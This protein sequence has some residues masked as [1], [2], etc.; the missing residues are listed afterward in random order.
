V[1]PAYLFAHAAYLLIADIFN[2]L[3]LKHLL[4]IM[5]SVW[6]AVQ[7]SAQCELSIS[8]HILRTG[9]PE[10]IPGVT[11]FI[12]ETGQYI[13]SDSTG[14]Y[15]VDNLCAGTYTI[16]LTAAGYDPLTERIVAGK[17]LHKDLWLRA[18]VRQLQAV[19]VLG[20]KKQDIVT[21]TTA[22]ISGLQLFQAG[23]MTLGESLKSVPGLNSIQTGPSISKPVIHGLHSNRVLILN[24]G[25]RQEGQQWGTE[26]A[27]EIDPFIA[28][29]ITI[30]KGA[31]S[32]R[33]GSDALAG[34]LLVEPRALQPE[35][36][37]EGEADLVAGSNG[38]SGGLSAMF[39][40]KGPAEGLNWRAQGTLKRAGNF[41]TA[42]YYLKN[43][44]L[45]ESDFSLAA[46]YKKDRFATEVYYSQF[47]NKVGIFEG[48]HVGNVADL[49][50]AF[51]RSRPLTPSY[52]SYDID[53]TYQ[54]IVHRLLKISGTYTFHNGGKMEAQF[55]DQHNKRDE[56]DIEL[57]YSTD[58][59]ILKLP[60]ISFQIQTQ[61]LD[62]VYH[63]PAR[64]NFTGLYG[65]SGA[66]Q[67]NVFK[68]IRYL[69]PNFRNYSG[70]AFAIERWSRHKLTLE[71]GL[72]YDY[73]WLQVYRLNSNSLQ[74]YHNTSMYENVTG[75]IGASYRASDKLSF[76]ANI[77]SAWR[78]PSVNELYIDGIHLS[79]ASYEKGD[80]SLHSERSYN[81]TF[82]GKY[83]S[84]KFL[85]E[86][87][88]YNNIINDF[89]YARPSLTPITLISGTYPLFNY[90]QANVNLKG[91]DAELRYQLCARLSIDSK[92]SLVRGWNKTIHDWLIFMPADRFDNSLRL[93]LGGWGAT[94]SWHVGTGVL[95]VLKQTRTPPNSD[96][97]PPPDGYTLLNANIGF[98]WP[99][100]KKQWTFDLAGYNLTNVAYRDYLNKFRYY[101][102]DLGIN[103]VL[104][105]R[106][107][108]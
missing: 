22:H 32:V 99:W 100:N 50:A 57:P 9:S 64:N 19:Q 8:G 12:R 42:H 14:A 61:A 43:T 49:D 83:E 4:L 20:E 24:N 68:G 18:D 78:A 28:D 41:S 105:A 52:F 87:S 108:F 37:L 23:G 86:L 53:R 70:G 47:H 29:R 66:T 46:N 67:G 63:A 92:I 17:P 82:S 3:L 72:R 71:A 73:R 107:S 85:A 96:Y 26:H 38:R 62:L 51:K 95:T 65:I 15:H 106:L 74:T 94:R 58:P 40:G 31:A 54:Q 69:V 6:T 79:A 98:E 25:V 16:M 45:S 56:Y 91:L 13:L 77:G 101:A 34:V 84:E 11:L 104:R 89:I 88:L 10:K 103:V 80:S 102:D 21:A 30:I 33:Y 44:G 7:A 5:L 81:F 90:T 76:T 97:V 75:T 2:D 60:Q 36:S 1:S 55:S 59:N 93:D 27:P 39:Q 35:R 48:S